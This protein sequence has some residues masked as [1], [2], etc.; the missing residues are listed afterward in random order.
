LALILRF[1]RNVIND[2]VAKHLHRV[3]TLLQ[4]LSLRA[5]SVFTIWIRGQRRAIV[6]PLTMGA[7]VA[8]CLNCLPR[9]L[10]D[11][12]GFGGAA[13]FDAY[14][15]WRRAIPPDSNVLVVPV[16]NSAAFAWFT[17]ERPSYLT[18]DQSSG[19][20]FSRATA[21]EVR[22]RSQVL[23]PLM[24]PDWRLLS[25]MTQMHGGSGKSSTPVRPLTR[26]RLMSVCRDPQV[27]FVVAEENIGFEP[28]RHTRPGGHDWY[29]YGCRIV[30]GMTPS[31]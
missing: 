12:T 29:L 21:L 15:D 18:V 11:E 31:A 4:S 30:N 5:I 13:E 26:E 24:D 28:L 17:L 20:V 2:R 9:A 10:H 23:L 3:G 14:S 1:T 16:R 19:V 22:R 27:N 6:F 7:L 25:N 8:A